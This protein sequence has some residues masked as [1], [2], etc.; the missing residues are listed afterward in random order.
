VGVKAAWLFAVLLG[1]SVAHADPLTIEIKPATSTWQQKKPVEVTLKVTNTSK[2]T[3]TFEVM[4]CSW[5]DHWKS[6]DRE[7][8]WEPW[9]CDKN[10]PSRVE[11][12]PGKAREWTL[13]MFAT[14]NAKLGAHPLA[15]TF[16]PRGGT[17]TTSSP[18]T[19]TVKR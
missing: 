16:T 19:V 2:T 11:L 5:E 12:A 8:T 15:M 4:G 14:A 9:D 17:P 13:P 10:A 7:L 3:V 6:S 18:V 1:A